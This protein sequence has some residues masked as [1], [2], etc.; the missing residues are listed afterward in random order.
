MTMHP[1]LPVKGYVAQAQDAVD[2]V[3]LNKEIEEWL[4]RHIEL[5]SDEL[6]I[7]ERWLSVARAHFEE[8]F[9]ALNRAIF[10]PK[11]IKLAGE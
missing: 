7:D 9:M 4:L 1:G 5:I 11:R 3:N 8:G 10:R 2:T 6:P